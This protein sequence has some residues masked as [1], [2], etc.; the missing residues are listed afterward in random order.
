MI[1]M[2]KSKPIGFLCAI[3]TVVAGALCQSA[4]AAT[5]VSQFGI[6][7]TFDKDYQ[8]GQFANGDYWV[9]GPVTI[10]RISPGWD[11][12]KNGSMVNPTSND[13]QAYDNR[14][15]V[16]FNSSKLIQAPVILQ[17]NSSLISSISFKDCDDPGAYC[18]G[19]VLRPVLRTAA[20]LT[21]L[22]TVPPDNVQLF[23][24]HLILGMKNLFS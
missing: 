19:G 9:V 24:G 8:V 23:S 22:N 1:Q 13:G 2:S 21:I 12:T 7:W 14:L 10:T 5:Q 18:P 11:G 16:S 17:P 4:Y 6:T 3:F 20:V 15:P